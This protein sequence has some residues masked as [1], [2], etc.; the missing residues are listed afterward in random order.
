MKSTSLSCDSNKFIQRNV[1]LLNFIQGA[2]D[3]FVIDML[4]RRAAVVGTRMCN[5]L[6]IGTMITYLFTD[7]YDLDK[8]YLVIPVR[9]QIRGDGSIK[10]LI[11]QQ[12]YFQ[13]VKSSKL[14]EQR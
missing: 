12:L 7:G 13:H 9:R 4:F 2:I 11:K 5:F 3:Y 6:M 1:H 8:K 14:T 10:V